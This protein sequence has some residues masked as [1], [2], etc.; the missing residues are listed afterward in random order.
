MKIE[1]I[2]IVDDDELIRK[3]LIE[4]LQRLGYKTFEASNGQEGFEIIRDQTIDLVFTDMKMPKMSGLDL[5]KKAK[6][7][8]PKTIIVVITAYG[9]IENAVQAMRLGAYN[10]LLKPFTADT[11]EAI[12]GKAN[13]HYSLVEENDY[14]KEKTN[15]VPSQIVGESPAMQE[16]LAVVKRVAASNASVFIHGE[17]GTGKEVI[18]H[19]IHNLSH[20]SNKPFIKVNCAAIP[21]TLIESEFF[22]HEK[23]AF[24]GASAKRLGR[25]ELANHG[26]LLLD[27]ISEI[28][29]SLQAKLLRVTQ[30]REFE[31]IGGTNPIKVDVRMISTSNRDIHE[32]IENKYMREDLFYRLNVI[33]VYIPPLRERKED[34]IPLSEYFVMQLCQENNRRIKELTAE[35]KK[36]LMDYPWFGN[37]RE[38]Q[39]V[40]ER[41]IV[42][43]KSDNLKIGVED[44]YISADKMPSPSR[45]DKQLLR[46]MTLKELE[47]QLIIETL[48]S[49]DRNPKKAAKTLGI[50]ED[51]LH[52]KIREY[53]LE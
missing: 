39:N 35:A 48:H 50:P 47:K 38:L 28:P 34:I 9:S 4:T 16:I 23:G 19:A 40:I 24:T 18:A 3:F 46:G 20:R 13:E 17:S 27:E 41:A 51:L 52:D 33:P 8:S 15:N 21:E 22:G 1:N 49:S 45:K 43:M 31:R 25:F 7:I 42:T 37:V 6:Q 12:L 36:L 53:E 29:H 11:V 2:L 14:L 32:L 30:E 44:I 10:Y 5:L 26:S